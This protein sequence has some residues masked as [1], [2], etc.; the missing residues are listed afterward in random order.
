MQFST[1]IYG[2]TLTFKCHEASHLQAERL[3]EFVKNLVVERGSEVLRDGNR[4]QVGWSVLTVKERG[5]GSFVLLEPDFSDDPFH[6]V[7]DNLACTL[8]VQT[9][10]NDFTSRIGVAPI[11]TSF[12]DKVVYSKSCVREQRIYLERRRPRPTDSGWFIGS[13]HLGAPDRECEELA[14]CYAYELLRLRPEVMKVLQL[15]PGY[16]VVFDGSEVEAVLAADDETV[17]SR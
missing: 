8:S 5:T 10:Q 3:V 15:P 17:F 13:N 11:V 2:K 7:R 4:I 6:G 12:Q 14:A 16:L 1:N 9:E